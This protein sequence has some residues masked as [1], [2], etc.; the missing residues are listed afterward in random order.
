MLWRAG[1]SR[2]GQWCREIFDNDEMAKGFRDLVNGHGQQW[3]PGW[4]KGQRGVDPSEPPVVAVTRNKL[5]MRARLASKAPHLNKAYA[6]QLDS[7]AGTNSS[8]AAARSWRN[9]SMAPG[10]REIRLLDRADEA[11]DPRYHDGYRFEDFAAGKERS[12]ESFSA[13]GRYQVIA[14]AEK[15]TTADFMGVGRSLHES[16]G[17]HD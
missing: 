14:G 10:C 8:R 17:N 12:A 13:A 4:V 9:R 2:T 6:D 5:M 7:R 3:P 1:G 11:A 16:R 15:G